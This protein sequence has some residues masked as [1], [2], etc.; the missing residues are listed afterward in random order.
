MELDKLARKNRR[1]SSTS[2]ELV[3]TL[4]NDFFVAVIPLIVHTKVV[5]LEGLQVIFEWGKYHY[6]SVFLL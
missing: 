3:F 2:S 5:P 4:T 6:R 1:T